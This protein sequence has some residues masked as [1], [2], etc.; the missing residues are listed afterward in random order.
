MLRRL[1]FAC[2]LAAVG[3][4][5]AGPVW[6][7]DTIVARYD[8]SY[9][10]ARIMKGS[11]SAT[12]TDANYTAA[13]EAKTVG[14]SKLL[15]KIKLSL[16]ASGKLAKANLIPTSYNYSRKKNDKR[17]ERSLA[18]ASNGD[19]VTEGN[20]YDASILKVMNESVMDPLSMLLKLSRAKSPCSGKHRAFD[21]RDVFDIRLSGASKNGSSVVCKVV[22][23]PVAGGE[24]DEGDTSPKNYEITL[25]PMT[26]AEGYIPV[27]IAGTSKGVGFDVS[28]TEITVNGSPLAY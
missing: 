12:L 21:G 15:A 24:V 28:A 6:A 19:L 22:Y 17:K 16:N 1:K 23:T 14:M 10:G 7:E 4:V 25:V 26:G 3:F 9:G 5:A 2:V 27:R 20:D 8:I 13:F 11:Y 18:F